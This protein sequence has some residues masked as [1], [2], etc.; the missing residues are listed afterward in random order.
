MAIPRRRHQHLLPRPDADADIGRRTTPLR[1]EEAQMH[2][3]HGARGSRKRPVLR[4]GIAV[5]TGAF[6]ATVFPAT[7]SADATDDYPIP[8][9]MILTTCTAE[10]ILAAASDFNPR[11][12]ERYIL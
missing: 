6:A 2:R 7:A 12:Y 5:L 9:R 8:H 4:A 1:S 10:Q 11:Y 3:P